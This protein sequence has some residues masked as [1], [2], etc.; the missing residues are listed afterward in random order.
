M[1]NVRTLDI[2][3]AGKTDRVFA[4][5]LRHSTSIRL[6]GL[7]RA[8]VDANGDVDP[9]RIPAEN[10]CNFQ[11]NLI[12]ESITDEGGKRLYSVDDVDMWGEEDDGTEKINAYVAALNPTKDKETVAGN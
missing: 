12:S 8:G 5:R 6:F 11:L 2:T 4:R 3:Y 7:L 1:A 9:N 10:V